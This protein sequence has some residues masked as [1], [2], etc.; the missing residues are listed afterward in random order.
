MVD[1][2]RLLLGDF[3][4]HLY[5][6]LLK[7]ASGMHLEKLG[8]ISIP[9]CIT[10]VQDNVV[11][12]GSHFGDS[13]LLRILNEPTEQGSLLEVIDTMTNIGPITDFTIVDVEKQ[14][15]SQVITCSGAFK[16]GSVR[17]VRNGIGIEEVASMEMEGL[18]SVYS[19]GPST[20]A[21]Y[22][23]FRKNC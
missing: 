21:T 22:V 3:Y 6:L 17:I 14:G 23:S 2:E 19:L 12:I 8:T 5:V 13:Q 7:T 18:K 16:E 10:H 1:D 15:Q 20:N 11:F 4:G 9:T